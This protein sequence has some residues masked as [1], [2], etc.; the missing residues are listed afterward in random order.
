M[1]VRDELT[2]FDMDNARR[3]IERRSEAIRKM[4]QAERPGMYETPA[5]AG[6]ALLVLIVCS[7]AFWLA[8]AAW[9]VR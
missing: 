2:D 5:D 1:N 9:I 7:L 6:K 4:R 3:R 8:L